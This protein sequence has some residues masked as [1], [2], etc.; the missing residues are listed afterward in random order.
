M[1]GAEMKNGKE[2]KNSA[3]LGPWE[4]HKLAVTL[5]SGPNAGETPPP[6]QDGC[7]D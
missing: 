3:F 1:G 7:E 4:K 2:K 6:P 5:L